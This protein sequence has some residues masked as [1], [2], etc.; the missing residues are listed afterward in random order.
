MKKLFVFCL[1][2]GMILCF[3]A[4][5]DEAGEY[6]TYTTD[7]GAY[8][9]ELVGETATI[10]AC[11]NAGATVTIPATVGQQ[12][13][14]VVGIGA[15]IFRNN[16]TL[17]AFA[18]EGANL[19]T[20]GPAAFAGCTALANVTLP[21]SVT[22]IGDGAFSGCTALATVTTADA[23]KTNTLPASL[24]TIGASAFAECTALTTINMQNAVTKIGDGAFDGCDNLA[25]VGLSN[26]LTE[27]GAFAFRDLAKLA[28]I[29]L[30][31]TLEVIGNRAFENCGLTTIRLPKAL[32]EMGDR[33]FLGCKK[34]TKLVYDAA[35]Y[36]DGNANTAIALLDMGVTSFALEIGA[37][38]VRIP[39]Y[40]FQRLP[41]SAVTFAA[42]GVCTEIADSA[43]FSCNLFTQITVPDTVNTIAGGAFSGCTALQSISLPFIGNSVKASQATSA[44][45]VFGYIFGTRNIAGLTE[46]SQKF[47]ASAD[48]VKYYVPAGLTSVTIR[49]G[50]ISY[51][52][53][54]GC[55]MVTTLNVG[56]AVDTIVAGALDDTAWFTAQNDVVY[57]G[58][59]L[60]AYK[61]GTT[62]LTTLAVADGTLSIAAKAL[63]NVETLTSITLPASLKN[64][65]ADAL[66]G[67][68][69]LSTIT[70]ATGN[71]AFSVENGVL[72][73]KEAT[74]LLLYPAKLAGATYTIPATVTTVAER[75]FDGNTLLTGIEIPAGITE[76]GEAAFANCTALTAFTVNAENKNYILKDDCLFSVDG[77]SLVAYP[78]G[79][80]ATDYTIKT[81][82][83][84]VVAF[85]FE[86]A[87]NLKT[88]TIANTVLTI[89]DGA[90]DGCINTALYTSL[91]S[92]PS[93]WVSGYIGD[94]PAYYNVNENT[95]VTINGMQ[96]LVI[97]DN[98]GATPTYNATLT[99]Y[100][101]TASSLTIPATISYTPAATEAVPTPEAVQAK[102]NKVGKRAFYET[103]VA[104]FTFAD[105]S[106]RDFG[107]DTFVNSAFWNNAADGVVYLNNVAIGYK[108]EMPENTVLS[109]KAG[110]TAIGYRAFNA[111]VNL[112]GVILPNTVNMI[113]DYAFNNIK[114]VNDEGKKVDKAINIYTYHTK[115]TQATITVGA[116]GNAVYKN[117]TV[118]YYLE[119]E[120][121]EAGNFWHLV[122]NVA[123][124][125]PAYVAPET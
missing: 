114:V 77:T 47:D 19:K 8:T 26:T 42:N 94:S 31:D 101:G 2:V 78:A 80:T 66:R 43:F 74:A 88:V 98:S 34:V 71:T 73:N 109:I 115:E 16:T 49:G 52:A 55:T 91:P 59:V 32:T 21:A 118:Y 14:P 24:T 44:Q 28:S 37:N 110:T 4:C 70:L 79:N 86:G 93:G 53:F 9:Y 81:G 100:L 33:V 119:T 22:T 65:G 107:N 84:D 50:D 97:V 41:I 64:I 1:V 23:V 62:P 48:A 67:C 6:M 46:V 122:S 105:T 36:K 18:V 13:Y 106:L 20:I 5:G 40:V 72:F 15:A 57:A 87:Y 125:W 124:I 25:T 102:V 111:Q 92:K 83:L 104:T 121:T 10:I 56:D 17:A 120:P 45:S 85:A 60:Y 117:A 61:A 69:A 99:K 108:G 11:N 3:A 76:I 58:K 116:N 82:V 63:M 12:A 75:A 123:T 27:I 96:F 38:A 35:S 30:P 51:N 54:D 103:S 95:L 113:A 7:D 29:D 68:K 89:G 39:A 90:F 112:A